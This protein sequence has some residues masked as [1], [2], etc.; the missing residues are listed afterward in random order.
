M[1]FTSVQ[2]HYASSVQ[3]ETAKAIYPS[4][5]SCIMDSLYNYAASCLWE[6]RAYLRI[7]SLKLDPLT[8]LP[9]SPNSQQIEYSFSSHVSNDYLTF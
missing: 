1:K 9:L 2:L 5:T 6:T 7:E 4:V 3:L 8:P